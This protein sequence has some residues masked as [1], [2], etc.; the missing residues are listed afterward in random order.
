MKAN[1]SFNHKLTR[2]A[3][4]VIVVAAV[5]AAAWTL[6]PR[7][8]SQNPAGDATVTARIDQECKSLP[9]TFEVP[10]GKTAHAFKKLALEAGTACH[11]SG[12]PE[13]QGFAIR[14]GKNKPVYMWSQ[15]QDQPPYEKGGPLSAL[16]L[17]SGSYTLSVAGGAGAKI[18]LAYKLK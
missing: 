6:A 9:Q 1:P 4:G 10:P 13:N 8:F 15:Y 11:D 12:A 2:S 7:A 5:L 17:E 3:A 18:E 16:A 14:D